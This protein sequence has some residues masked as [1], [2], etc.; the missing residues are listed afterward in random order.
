MSQG[1]STQCRVQVHSKKI[2]N[3]Q[4][5]TPSYLNRSESESL[6]VPSDP[7]RPSATPWTIQS[8]GLSRPEYWSGLPFPSP[9]DLPN[10]G[11]KPRSPALQ[12]DSLPA[13]PPGKPLTLME[14]LPNSYTSDCQRFAYQI[15][16]LHFFHNPVSWR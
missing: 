3:Y 14:V 10:P 9:G 11:I 2:H 13:K 5:L 12:A 15:H 8:M 16:S 6:S 4:H 7:L 1:Q